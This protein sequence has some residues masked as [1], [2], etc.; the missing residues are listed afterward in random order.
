MNF[1]RSNCACKEKIRG[2]CLLFEQ[3]CSPDALFASGSSVSRKAAP[4][5]KEH[6]RATRPVCSILLVHLLNTDAKMAYRPR[7]ALSLFI[8]TACLDWLYVLWVKIQFAM[9]INAW[10]VL[11]P[12]TGFFYFAFALIA[13]FGI[14]KKQRFGVDLASGVIMFGAV[15]ATISYLLVFNKYYLIDMCILPIILINLFTIIYLAYSR[16]YFQPD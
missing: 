5:R 15:S 14:F 16:R 7:N 12:L 2:F 11:I 3:L 9:M 8:F 6:V 13:C 10:F 4:G 1:T